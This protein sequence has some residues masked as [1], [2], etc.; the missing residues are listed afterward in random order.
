MSAPQMLY[1]LDDEG[2]PVLSGRSSFLELARL[3]VK[4]TMPGVSISRAEVSAIGGTL[5][6]LFRNTEEHARYN[7]R[8][9]R[10]K[11]SLRGIQ[12]KLHAMDH[13]ALQDIVSGS[14]PLKA[15]ASKLETMPNSSARAKLAEISVFDSGPGFAAKWLGK[16]LSEI[17]TDEELHAIQNCF[18]KHASSKSISSAG[19]GLPHVVEIL[20]RRGGFLRLRTGKQSLYYDFLNSADSV[21]DTFPALKFWRP[22]LPTHAPAVGSLLTILIPIGLEQ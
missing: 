21:F 22:E 20:R 7:E 19:L 8:G 6:E 15:Y 10:I 13:K 5:Y 14:K 3:I 11:L 18:A 4:T 1:N 12:A 9:D 2:V 17:S 16:P